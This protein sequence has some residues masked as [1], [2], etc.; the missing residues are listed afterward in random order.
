MEIQKWPFVSVLL[1][2]SGDE[3]L[4][5]W[6]SLGWF[7]PLWDRA[8]RYDSGKEMDVNLIHIYKKTFLKCTSVC[9]ISLPVCF[10][11][12]DYGR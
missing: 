5:L 7:G 10:T 4:K 9:A 6:Q 8:G 11:L 1:P 2:N 3:V 12:L